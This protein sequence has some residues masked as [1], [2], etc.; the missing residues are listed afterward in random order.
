MFKILSIY[1]PVNLPFSR[2]AIFKAV[3]VHYFRLC[4]NFSQSILK[5]LISSLIFSSL[6][7][8]FLQIA[9]PLFSTNERISDTQI[10]LFEEDPIESRVDAGVIF[11]PASHESKFDTDLF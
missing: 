9:G 2:L 8:F 10:E 3:S 6:T 1:I 4:Q 5:V 7:I 11:V